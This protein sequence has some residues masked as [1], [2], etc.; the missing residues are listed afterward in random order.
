LWN[1]FYHLNQKPQLIESAEKH[2]KSRVP[3]EQAAFW[4]WVM[5]NQESLPLLQSFPNGFLFINGSKDLGMA[6]LP[7]DM[8]HIYSRV[9]PVWFQHD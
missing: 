1:S 7:R 3:S 6:T 8:P 5:R 2:N 4:Y 9:G